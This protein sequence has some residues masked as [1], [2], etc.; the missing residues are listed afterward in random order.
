MKN[1]S[2]SLRMYGDRVSMISNSQ[3]TFDLGCQYN[4]A[5]EFQRESYSPFKSIDDTD[6]VAHL[7]NKFTQPQKSEAVFKDPVVDYID[8]LMLVFGIIE[9]SHH[10]N[11]LKVDLGCSNA[12]CYRF[13]CV[14]EQNINISSVN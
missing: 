10:S 2:R 13:E 12:Q 11:T 9:G 14:E 4:L 1:S 5:W 6:R 8:I 3:V 7:S